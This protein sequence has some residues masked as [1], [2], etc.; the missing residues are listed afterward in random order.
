MLE[1]LI[2][3]FFC[4]SDKRISNWFWINSY[5]P[6]TILTLCYLLFVLKLGPALMKNRPPL[7]LKKIIFVYNFIQIVSSAGLL[8]K[9]SNKQIYSVY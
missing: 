4:F 2:F 8:W 5:G 9:V 3:F 7:K 1:N 6:V